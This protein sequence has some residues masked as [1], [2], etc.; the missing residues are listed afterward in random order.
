M[1]NKGTILV[2]LDHTLAH[3]KSGYG[4]KF[5][6]GDPVPLMVERVR[7]WLRSGYEVRI[8]TARWCFVEERP[9]FEKVVHEWLAELGLPPLRVTNEKD[10]TVVEIYDDR[11]VRVEKDTGRRIM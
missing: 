9:R 10:Y 8:F 1:S 5:I 3:Y 4:P 7:D 6:I 11:A 2:D